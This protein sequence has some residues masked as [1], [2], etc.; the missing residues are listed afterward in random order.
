MHRII[1]QNTSI[2]I[3]ERFANLRSY[4]AESNQ[5]IILLVDS[6]VYALYPLYFENYE[7]I[8]VPAGEDSKSLNLVSELIEQLLERG[9][10][11]SGYL[12][13]VG[14]G[15]VC[16]LTGF[17][18]SIYMRGVKFAFVPTTLLA[19][20]DASIGGK[21]GVNFGA[22]KNMIGTINQ[23]EFILI[24]LIFLE[25][26]PQ[27]EFVSGM[28]EVVKHACIRSLSYFD[29]LES[30]VDAI[31]SRDK[32][33]MTELVKH[34]V[35]IKTAVVLSD[36]RELGLRKILNYGHTF[37]HAIEKKYQIPHG[38]AVSLGIVVVNR[39]AV[40][41]HHLDA[42]AARRVLV[43]LSRFELPTDI[44]TLSMAH[45]EIFYTRDKKRTGDALDL[46]LLSRI[47]HVEIVRKSIDEL[48][49][50]ITHET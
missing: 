35:E 18:A 6:S 39:I 19:Q 32:E 37:G 21:N 41:A 15:V 36:E 20:V 7:V 4:L 23:P 34:S 44:S 12:I 33:V 16:D 48:K 1:Y 43:L 24:D 10:D 29:F 8:V 27:E 22:L 11:R 38:F 45:L 42:D 47:G 9:L 30:K 17:V 46:I 28:A 49:N 5:R 3:G 25:T 31:L 14:G 13:G 2:H 50:L 40:L 26:L